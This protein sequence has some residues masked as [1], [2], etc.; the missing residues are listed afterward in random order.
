[1]AS[2]QIHPA[3]EAMKP[4]ARGIAATFGKNCEVV[5]HDLSE[6]SSSL[7]FKAGSVTNREIGAPVTNLVLE[8]LQRYGD[9]TEDLIGYLNRTKDGKVLK[10]STIF[11]RDN[12]GKIIG[13][14][15]INFD[16]T[17]FQLAKNIL[18]DFCQL[19]DLAEAGFERTQEQFARDINEV[20][21]NVVENVLQELGKPVPV[22]TKEEK[23]KAVE[24]LDDRGIFLVKGAVDVVAQALAVSKYTIY[25]YLEEARA[26]KGN[27]RAVL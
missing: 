2:D 23:V 5:L 6:P 16:L 9:A 14:L 27:R 24:M 10:S 1:M 19:K 25:N 18:E 8:A 15:C 17:E 22:M 26:L 3:L 12:S 4:V 7:I 13:C 21:D 20:V 11:I